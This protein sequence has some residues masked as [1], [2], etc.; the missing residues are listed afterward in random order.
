MQLSNGRY[1]SERLSML[2]RYYARFRPNTLLALLLLLGMGGVLL[3]TL[4]QKGLTNDEIVHIP[5]GY[6]SLTTGDFRLNNEQP[7]L[8]KLLAA[9]PLLPLRLNMPSV[10]A[11][12]WETPPDRTTTWAQ[13]FWSANQAQFALIAFLA[14]IPAIGLTLLLG[15]LLFAWGRVLLGPTAALLALLLYTTEPTILAHGRIVHTDLP[16]AFGLLLGAVATHHYLTAPSFRRAVLLGGAIGIGVLTKFSLL[17]LAPLPLLFLLVQRIRNSRDQRWVAIAGQATLVVICAVLVV[18]VAYWFSRQPLAAADRAWVASTPPSLLRDLLLQSTV[19]NAVLPTDFVYGAYYQY[20]HSQEGHISYLLGKFSK[21]GWWYYFPVAFALKTTVPFLILSIAA[22]V[23]SGWQIRQRNWRIAAILVPLA[24]FIG[25]ALTSRINIGIRHFLPAYPLLCLLSGGF[26]AQVSAGIRAPVWRRVLIGGIAVVVMGTAGWIY[27][28]YLPYFNMLAAGRPHWE[29][30]GDSNL[31]WGDDIPAL[32]A[33]LHSQGETS[34]PA[35]VSAGWVTLP[36]H[37]I[38]YQ[39]LFANLDEGAWGTRYVAI[40]QSA[41]SGATVPSDLRTQVRSTYSQRTPEIVFGGTISLYLARSTP[42]P[43]TG[44][45]PAA[46]FRASM[47]LPDPPATMRPGEVIDVRVRVQNVGQG[48]WPVAP[49][50]GGLYCLH[51]GNR[52]FSSTDQRLVLDDARVAL[53]YPLYPGEE[54]IVF[55]RVTAPA[56]AGNYLLEIDLLQEGVTWA[57]TNGGQAGRT[58]V[59]VAP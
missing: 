39:P 51:L 19:I 20:R 42:P 43:L 18:N 56:T 11:T 23:W 28:N 17:V 44:P 29:L 2:M 24:L 14:R 50:E 22:C 31:E 41:Q 46:S 10:P 55:L 49:P 25:V 8:P 52:W 47:T 15:W 7:S 27:P 54:A 30:L 12:A 35:A 32:A 34:I 4:M 9:L 48:P 33:Y 59:R 3:S 26:L 58:V 57:A 6:R 40:G 21:T 37:G 36:L 1:A 13:A 16:A 5:A 45:L 53:L 38:A